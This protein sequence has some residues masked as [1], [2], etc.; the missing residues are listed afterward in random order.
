MNTAKDHY[1]QQLAAIYSWMA[2]TPE[3]AI[4]RNHDLLRQLEV[5][6]SQGLAIDLGAGLGFQSIPLAELGF[7]VV[8][9]DFCESLLSELRAGAG[10]LPIRTIH[11]NILNFS[12]YVEE[13][14]QVIVCMG[15][16]LTHLES[17]ESVQSLLLSIE[18]ALAAQGKLILMFR[19]YISVEPQGTQRFIPVQSDESIILTCFLEYREDVVEVYDLVYRKEGDRWV[20]STSSYP[21]LRIDKNWV[22]DQL[23]KLGLEVVQTTMIN[24]MICI[25][26]KKL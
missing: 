13:Q 16:T 19:D 26:A 20:L 17:L 23:Q 5:N 10:N 8:A 4:K 9:I 7:S 25:V 24:G 14:A 2:G 18:A 11:D 1:D 21:K 22:C 6:S 3:A 15:D 12:K